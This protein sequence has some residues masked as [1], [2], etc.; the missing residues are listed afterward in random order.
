MNVKTLRATSVY[1]VATTG[2]A[3]L[4]NEMIQRLRKLG[5][6]VA[7]SGIDP[8]GRVFVRVRVANDEKAAGAALAACDGRAFSLAT[9]YGINRR[10]IAVGAQSTEEPL[11]IVV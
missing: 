1:E 8:G 4:L 11:W 5:V 2:D 10:E 9:G 7:G 6:E 3:A